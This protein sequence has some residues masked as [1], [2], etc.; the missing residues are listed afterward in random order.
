MMKFKKKKKNINFISIKMFSS[1][2]LN[3]YTVCTIH[4]IIIKKLGVSVIL[5]LNFF[6]IS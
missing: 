3:G 5:C 1:C 6:T 4:T 2:V